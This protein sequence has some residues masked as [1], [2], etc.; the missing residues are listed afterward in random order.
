MV[1]LVRGLLT[2]F[3]S[4]RVVFVLL[5]DK[6]WIET[7]FAK[8]YKEMAEVHKDTQTTFGGR[9]AEKAIQLSFVLPEADED[10]REAYLTEILKT[11]KDAA[12]PEEQEQVREL[13]DIQK[14]IRS[15]L[16]SADKIAE[17]SEA[18]QRSETRIEERISKAA[19]E[20][21]EGLR[22]ATRTILN[23]ESMLRAATAK[24]A[25][26]EIRQHGLDPLK[27]YLPGNPRRIKRIVNMV[28]AYQASAQSTSGVA[29]GSDKWKQLVLWI[30]IMSEYPQVWHRLVKDDVLSATLFDAIQNSGTEKTIEIPPL[31]DEASDEQKAIA[32]LL[33]T[34]G[35]VPLLR[36]DPF[37]AQKGAPSPARI[38]TTARNWLRR[39]TPIE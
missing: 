22:K 9:F 28:G 38:D 34:P 5:G 13:E 20:K 35:L 3:R 31:D 18:I 23:R 7:A 27:N 16:A 24:S 10:T 17:Q 4:P 2:I 12:A 11:G 29:L 21:Q 15:E 8:V 6:D 33:K 19:P 26:A 39:L 32:A 25:E 37:A 14:E 36:G 1:E 30:V